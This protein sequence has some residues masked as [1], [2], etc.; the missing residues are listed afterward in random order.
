M[1]RYEDDELPSPP[2]LPFKASHSASH[3][4]SHQSS[5]LRRD[6]SIDDDSLPLVQWPLECSDAQV[7]RVTS[8]HVDSEH[9]PMRHVSE[10]YVEPVSEPVNPDPENPPPLPP[11]FKPEVD[12]EPKYARVDVR[13]K[14]SSKQLA[15]DSREGT[16]L[17]HRRRG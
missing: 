17:R 8:S 1:P 12:D 13:N 7:T 2:A 15:Q 3:T 10:V 6:E 11:H 5:L 4:T 14:R 16:P 9:F